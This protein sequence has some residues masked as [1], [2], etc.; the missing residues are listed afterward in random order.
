MF[1]YYLK[2]FLKNSLKTYETPCVFVK[3]LTN[4]IVL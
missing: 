4:I 1:L 3:I 2:T